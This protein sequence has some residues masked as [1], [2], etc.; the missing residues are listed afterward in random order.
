MAMQNE[1]IFD[2]F[3]KSAQKHADNEALAWI[4]GKN[5]ESMTYSELLD[6][7]NRLAAGM[8][9]QG[10][11]KGDKI[12]LM[13]DNGPD[14]VF[15]DLAAARLG[16]VV[17]PIHTTYV[18]KYIQFKI[19]HAWVAWFFV[20][21]KYCDQHIQAINQLKLKKV[22]CIGSPEYEQ[23]FKS[24][25]AFDPEPVDEQ[26]MH[27]IIYTSGTTGQ[28]KGVMLS[29][30]NI[31]SNV[32]NAKL[33]VP[34]EPKDRFFSFLPLSHA[35][36]RT[37][38]YYVPLLS[39][40]SIY[41][42]QSKKTLAEDIK[43]A[44]PTT[45]IAVPR[46]FEKVYDTVFSK[47][48]EGRILKQKLFYR[49]LKLGSLH[50]K[51]ELGLLS[52]PEFHILDSVVF[53]KIRASLGGKLRVVISGGSALNKHIMQFFED[54]GILILEG[55]GL[56][57]TSPIVSTNTLDHHLFGSV[58][59]PLKSVQV[60]I[61][62]EHEILV[63]GD[64][65]MQG[66]YKNDKDTKEVIDSYG[67]FHT[68]DLGQIDAK[69]FITIVGRKKEMIVLSTGK[70]IAPVPIEQSL[71]INPFIL[72]AMVYGD[73]EKHISAFIVPDFAELE[74][75]AQKYGITYNLPEVL[76]DK[77][78]IELY[79]HEISRALNHFPEIEQV[80][81]FKLLREE[82]TQENDTLT[83]TLKLKRN[84]IMDKYLTK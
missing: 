50:R 5:Y 20:G 2:F 65:V 44:Q 31:L 35:M 84:R 55:Y 36:E 1:T 11:K 80:R 40:A 10:L 30:K 48:K 76:D 79:E 49:A 52:T 38:G 14:W 47:V 64:S 17:V 41:Y 26:A 51:H 61:N 62:D 77:R 42:G 39:G 70:N 8:Q 63:K 57:E 73:K 25:D 32:H 72:Q 33:S 81:N 46:I 19:N 24:S 28:P 60:K 67:W 82:F 21:K 13:L 68:G 22:I 56:T 71:E 18:S 37:A 3:L 34:I 12:A 7:V 75:L 6:K 69:G 78:V 4:K 9:K 15:I 29:H 66:Y 74:R 83:P 16:V 27:T 23:L 43:K 53:K 59:L 45:L 54:V 58:G